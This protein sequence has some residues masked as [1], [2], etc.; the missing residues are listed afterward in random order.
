MRVTIG[1]AGFLRA[2]L[3]QPRYLFLQ[4]ATVCCRL[5]NKVDQLLPLSIKEV[6][7]GCVSIL[8]DLPEQVMHGPPLLILLVSKKL[9]MQPLVNVF[10][11]VEYAQHVA[12]IWPK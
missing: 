11:Q 12:D 7:E 1:K 10:G 9:R 5:F 6:P 2:K 4:L 8:A 3:G